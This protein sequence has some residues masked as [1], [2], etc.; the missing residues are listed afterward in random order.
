MLIESKC[1]PE[2]SAVND[3]ASGNELVAIR[4][5]QVLDSA[6]NDGEGGFVVPWSLCHGLPSALTFDHGLSRRNVTAMRFGSWRTIERRI[7]GGTCH[8]P[9]MPLH[10]T[11]LR[12]RLTSVSTQP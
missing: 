6:R 1:L 9:S 4:A 7:C 3:V 8:R 5:I 12:N 2:S 10:L 11:G